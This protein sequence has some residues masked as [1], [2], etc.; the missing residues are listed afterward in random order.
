MVSDTQQNLPFEVEK[1]HFDPISTNIKLKV[2]I[3]SSPKEETV[4]KDFFLAEISKR[5]LV[6]NFNYDFS[7]ESLTGS[8]SLNY[9]N[10]RYKNE[11]QTLE[12]SMKGDNYALKVSKN[13]ATYKTFGNLMLAVIILNAIC[14]LIGFF[15]SKFIGL[16][17]IL[18]CQLICYSQL[19][20]CDI[21]RWPSGFTFLN[22][23]KYST[24]YNGLLDFTD[25]ILVSTMTKKMHSLG[26]KKLLIENFNLNFL[27]LFI[28][29]LCFIV[30][31][32][33]RK[34]R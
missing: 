34:A 13:E 2:L 32:V 33:I 15:T 25:Y 22:Y 16:E 11:T 19:M 28:V 10:T 4:I 20:I 27:I 7:V 29:F 3:S 21:S 30:C 8:I 17:S 5:K 9:Q 14:L 6:I 1:E 24:G 26:L 31:S 23:L 12:F 18:T